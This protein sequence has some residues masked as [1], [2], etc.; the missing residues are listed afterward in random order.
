MNRDI[1]MSSSRRNAI[2]SHI[3]SDAPLPIDLVIPQPS[4]TL[5]PVIVMPELR[6]M[7]SPRTSLAID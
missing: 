5:Y 1:Y 2:H 4:V 7:I 3:H 6:A